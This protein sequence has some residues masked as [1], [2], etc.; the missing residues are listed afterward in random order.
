MQCN[1]SADPDWFSH[2]GRRILQDV[3]FQPLHEY[4][5]VEDNDGVVVA[6]S[7]QH[8]LKGLKHRVVFQE[9]QQYFS[10]FSMT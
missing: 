10:H 7:D 1:N 5:V 8:M 9:G 4:L 3:G 2:P 6:L